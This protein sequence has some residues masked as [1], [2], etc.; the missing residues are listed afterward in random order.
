MAMVTASMRFCAGRGATT[1]AVEPASYDLRL[2]AS[3]GAG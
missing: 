1:A 2:H 3:D